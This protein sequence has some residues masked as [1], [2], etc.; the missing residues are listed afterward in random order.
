[1]EWPRASTNTGGKEMGLPGPVYRGLRGVELRQ[2]RYDH[3][4]LA[5]LFLQG[6]APGEWTYRQT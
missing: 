4:L 2:N 1:M 5:K 3:I 6:D